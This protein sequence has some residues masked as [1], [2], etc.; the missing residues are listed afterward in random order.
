MRQAAS[1][2][3]RSLWSGP[4]HPLKAFLPQGQSTGLQ[5]G[6]NA[7]TDLYF[8]EF[9]SKHKSEL[10]GLPR[11]D[12]C[13]STGKLAFMSLRK[14]LCY[15]SLHSAVSV[16][17]IFG[18]IHVKPSTSAKVPNV[19]FSFN[20]EATWE[21]GVLLQEQWPQDGVLRQLADSQTLIWNFVLCKLSQCRALSSLS[22]YIS[23]NAAVFENFLEAAKAPDAG[24]PF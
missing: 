11:S 2:A 10:R 5:I 23:L 12:L 14:L 19:I 13:G 17:R 7:D 1:Y 20:I 4:K 9:F 16:P 3:F 18:G 21:S 24:N 22:F 6:R 15:V 8:P